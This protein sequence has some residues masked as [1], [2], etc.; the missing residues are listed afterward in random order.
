MPALVGV[1]HAYKRARGFLRALQHLRPRFSD[2]PRV[3]RVYVLA[4]RVADHGRGRAPGQSFVRRAHVL[5]ARV[6]TED[7]DAVGCMLHEGA[8]ASLRRRDARLGLAPFRDV[9]HVDDDAFDHR[10]VEL[11]ACRDLAPA[12]RTVAMVD[13]H[14]GAQGA[15]GLP[16]QLAGLTGVKPLEVLGFDDQARVG[17]ADEVVD[18]V[19]GQVLDR[20]GREHDGSRPIDDDDGVG[21]VHQEPAETVF[22]ARERG[23]GDLP[24]ARAHEHDAHDEQQTRGHQDR[25][26]V[27]SARAHDTR[28]PAEPDRS[29][30]AREA[31]EAPHRRREH[32]RRTFERDRLRGAED[33]ADRQHRTPTGRVDDDCRSDH[34]DPNPQA[35]SQ[36][37]STLPVGDRR[38]E[39]QGG[40]GGADEHHDGNGR[41][42]SHGPQSE[43]GRERDDSHGERLA[44]R[45]ETGTFHPLF[46]R[47]VAGGN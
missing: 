22:A 21:R 17:P 6:E 40:H 39:R 16:V 32:G 44:G 28:R 3:V 20:L 18:R 27:A 47:I 9:V 23:C 34:L 4:E 13:A 37:V 33:E 43:Q 14:V 5:A 31:D 36:A 29:L 10:I 24:V 38:A 30:G 42:D 25:D 11:I 1:P 26:A 46:C 35:E 12:D 8:K 45:A 7:D 41:E 15:T 2:P 19:T